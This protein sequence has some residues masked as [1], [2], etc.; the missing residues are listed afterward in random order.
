MSIKGGILLAIAYGSSR[1]T[2]DVDFSTPEQY[3][4]FDQTA[5]VS[6]FTENLA[7][8]V[9][10]LSYGLDCRIQS[11][12]VNPP[13]PNATFPTLTVTIGYATKNSREHQRLLTGQC[14]TVIA[15]DYSFNETTAETEE[16]EIRGGGI[17]QA[18]SLHDLVAEKYRAILQQEARN[19]IRRQDAYDLYRLFQRFPL[20]DARDRQRVLDSLRAKAASRNLIIDRNSIANPEI[21]SRSKKEYNQLHL[22]IDEELPPFDEVYATV[23]MF[24]E[25][26]PW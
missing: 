13:K 17:I 12:K 15:L 2:R 18:Y 24:Y 26:L 3:S 11:I 9:E 21:I 20:N 25:N 5:F 6:E 16:L 1:Y 4:K 10:E 23:R 19:R 14:P 7:R 8:A 22:E